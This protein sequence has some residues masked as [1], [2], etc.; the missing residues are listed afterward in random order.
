MVSSF[1]HIGNVCRYNERFGILPP[2]WGINW[3]NGSVKQLDWH[4]LPLST[5]PYVS[6]SDMSGFSSDPVSLPYP[7]WRPQPNNFQVLL[8]SGGPVLCYCIFR[9]SLPTRTSPTFWHFVLIQPCPYRIKYRMRSSTVILNILMAETFR[10]CPKIHALCTIH[11]AV[12]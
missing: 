4:S 2:T 3:A 10:L 8:S 1:V 7:Q 12:L 5:R 11:L 9:V 6:T